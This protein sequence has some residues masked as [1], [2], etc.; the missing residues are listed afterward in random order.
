MKKAKKI[1]LLLTICAFANLAQA[2]RNI[3]N[4]KT[5]AGVN[6]VTID[7]KII[8]KGKNTANLFLYDL[9][10]TFTNQSTCKVFVPDIQFNSINQTLEPKLTLLADAK[11]RRKSYRKLITS[12]IKLEPQLGLDDALFAE[13][14]V[15]YFTEEKACDYTE[16]I[17]Y[18]EQVKK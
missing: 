7:G 2:Q 4:C 18:I 14:I 5:K 11:N 8:F 6:S 17:G 1:L 16:T 3:C 15:G 13:V 9:N 12:K 10:V